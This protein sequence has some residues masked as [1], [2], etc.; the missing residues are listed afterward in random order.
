MKAMPFFPHFA[1]RELLLWLII[2]ETLAILAVV[3]PGHL[4][5]KADLLAPAPAGIKPE[6]YFL[7]MFQVLKQL[8]PHI[9]NFEGEVVGVLFF[10]FC[11]L[12]VLVVPFLDYGKHSRRMLTGLAGLAVAFFIVMTAWG[13]FPNSLLLAVILGAGLT[14]GILAMTVFF[15]D[16]KET[17]VRVF[18]VLF[19][20]GLVVLIAAIRWWSLS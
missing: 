17:G 7:F 15:V 6:W 19:V 14:L 4:G 18:N 13:W 10:G 3:F 2:L 5:I 16:R 1:L 12:V 8:P 9:L 20:V 11:G